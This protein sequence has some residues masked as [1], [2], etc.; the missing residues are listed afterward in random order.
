MFEGGRGHD[1]D[2]IQ[3]KLNSGH[4]WIDHFSLSDYD[5]GLID[6]TRGSTDI[7]ISRCHF[8]NHD[9][10]MLIGA[11]PSHRG[12]RCIRITIHHC[13]FDGTQQKHSHVRSG[14][15]RLYNN[16]TRHWGIYAVCASIES[17]IYSQC[18]IYEAGQKKVAF[19][20]LCLHQVTF[21]AASLAPEVES[22][23]FFRTC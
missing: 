13:F 3:I 2:R 6:I 8:A 1:V 23:L 18:N 10:M 9:K 12:D 11:D 14:K 15:V 5:N 16:Y 20:H 17:Q 22:F 19:K 21:T 7:T 4:I